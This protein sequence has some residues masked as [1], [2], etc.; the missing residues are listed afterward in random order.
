M[1]KSILR[2]RLVLLSLSVVLV[3]VLGG[4]PVAT[5]SAKKVQAH[6]ASTTSFGPSAPT[7]VGPAATG[8]KKGCSLLTGP[9][10]DDLDRVGVGQ[11]DGESERCSRIVRSARDAGADGREPTSR[12]AARGGD[13]RC[14]AHADHPDG[15]VPAAGRGMRQHQ[16]VGWWGDRREG[17]ERRR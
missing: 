7:F 8:C 6:A 4:A 17:A 9:F 2:K 11:R 13:G 10:I 3:G 14:S 1:R 12:V 16:H 5:A 15:P